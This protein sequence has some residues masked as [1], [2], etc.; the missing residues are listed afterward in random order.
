MATRALSQPHEDLQRQRVASGRV[1]SD[2]VVLLEAALRS[3]AAAGRRPCSDALRM[4]GWRLVVRSE[5][6]SLR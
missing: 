1:A 6:Y 2:R 3:G 5:Q 4:D